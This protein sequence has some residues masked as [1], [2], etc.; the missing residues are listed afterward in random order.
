[1]PHSSAPMKTRFPRQF[2]ATVTALTAF[3]AALF[4]GLKFADLLTEQF[5]GALVV[6]TLSPYADCDLL[7]EYA[8]RTAQLC[9]PVLLHLFLI[10]LAAYVQF[11]NILLAVLFFLRGLSA[12]MAARFVLILDASAAV[13]L[14]PLMHA[15]ASILMLMMVFHIRTEDGICSFPDSLTAMM[16]T[17]GFSCGISVL[18]ALVTQYLS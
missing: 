16:I 7:P 15:A 13:L 4:L 8:I 12:G 3:A 2:S 18:A 14:L 11:E 5:D 17:G 1:M 6:R 9:A 10:W